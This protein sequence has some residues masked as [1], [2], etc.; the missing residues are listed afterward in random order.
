MHASTNPFDTTIR[1][2]VSLPYPFQLFTPLPCS[3]L[4]RLLPALI[5]KM[6]PNQ[7]ILQRYNCLFRSTMPFAK[8]AAEFLI[9]ADMQTGTVN[10]V[11]TF[12]IVASSD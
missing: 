7:G 2:I 6:L 12:H 8:V 5:Q 3:Y 1:I 4:P 10:A 11:V 9:I